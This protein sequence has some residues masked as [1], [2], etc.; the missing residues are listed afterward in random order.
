VKDE[1]RPDEL[2]HSRVCDDEP[3]LVKDLQDAIDWYA[4]GPHEFTST[5]AKAEVY[6]SWARTAE[7]KKI[8]GDLHSQVF[9]HVLFN[10]L[11]NGWEITTELFKGHPVKVYRRK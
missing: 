9:G 2:L 5:E 3:D 11:K 8:C 1:L 4:G 10:R 7:W 6:R